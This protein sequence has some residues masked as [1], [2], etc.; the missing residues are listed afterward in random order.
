MKRAKRNPRR[1]VTLMRARVRVWRAAKMFAGI[2][3]ADPLDV[4][5]MAGLG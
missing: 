2:L 1:A 4:L 5:R 3:G